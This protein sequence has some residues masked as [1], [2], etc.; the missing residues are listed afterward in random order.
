MPYKTI[1]DLPPGVKNNLPIEAQ[2]IYM[3][4]FNAAYSALKCGWMKKEG[5]VD[6]H[7]ECEV[8]SHKTAWRGV[9]EAYA[10]NKKNG[11]WEKIKR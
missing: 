11:K 7:K 1:D 10:K 2:K 8:S 5:E 3:T 6:N 9:K 4:S